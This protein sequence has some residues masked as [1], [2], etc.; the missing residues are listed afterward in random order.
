METGD[1]EVD[2]AIV[3]NNLNDLVSTLE[4]WIPEC[5]DELKPTIGKVFDT[6][7]EEGNFYKKY[8]HVVGFSVSSSSETKDKDGVKW[9][10][11]L[12]SKEGFEVEKKIV[13]AE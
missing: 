10:Y 1:N 12:C 7:E 3:S 9:K 11:F 2:V 4:E 8:A 13:Q 6:L 5:D